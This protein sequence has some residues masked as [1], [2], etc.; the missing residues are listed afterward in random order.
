MFLFIFFSFL[1]MCNFEDFLWY[2]T[3]PI[4]IEVIPSKVKCN[5]HAPIVIDNSFYFA[6]F[7]LTLH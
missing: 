1:I 4:S 6:M 5:E 7:P 2:N 3:T